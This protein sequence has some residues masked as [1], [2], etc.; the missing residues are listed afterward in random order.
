VAELLRSGSSSAN[1][2]LLRVAADKLTNLALSH[3]IAM[4]R[5]LR[6]EAHENRVRLRRRSSR[7]SL[8]S[9]TAS[10]TSNPRLREME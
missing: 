2:L 9:A 6:D 3:T 7:T 4:E 5:L 10:A 8:K 1:S